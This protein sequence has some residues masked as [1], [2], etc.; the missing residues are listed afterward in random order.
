[1]CLQYGLLYSLYESIQNI[2][3]KI[4]SSLIITATCSSV[5]MAAQNWDDHDRSG[6]YTALAMAKAYLYS[7][8]PNAYYLP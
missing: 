3:A 1:M 5:L 7:C 8:D 4:C 2:S 6:K